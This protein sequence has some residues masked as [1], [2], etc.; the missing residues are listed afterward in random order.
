MAA[1]S[2]D[3]LLSR[4]GRRYWE[5]HLLNPPP[6]IPEMV[7]KEGAGSEAR[8]PFTHFANVLPIYLLFAQKI[9]TTKGIPKVVEIG[10]GTGRLLYFLLKELNISANLSGIDYSSAVI[11]YAKSF[12]KHPKLKFFSYSESTLP[13]ESNAFEIVLSSHVIEHIS[14]TQVGNY[15]QEIFR[16][17]KSNGLLLLGT[18]NRSLLQDLFWKNPTDE[19]KFRFVLPHEHEYYGQGLKSVIARHGFTDI[20]LHGI[21]N[22]SARRLHKALA[23]Q[24]KPNTL[25]KQIQLRSIH[26]LRTYAPPM[27]IDWIGKRKTEQIMQQ[28]DIDYQILATGSIYIKTPSKIPVDNFFL[29]AQKP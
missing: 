11:N 26:L 1:V 21:K 16:I 25:A 4:W 7:I 14:K 24:L 27:L 9:N 17:L 2:K 3:S 13:L 23:R 20:R 22:L 8:M 18:P 28:L 10:C 29:L 6:S 15:L 5:W 19:E 12:Y